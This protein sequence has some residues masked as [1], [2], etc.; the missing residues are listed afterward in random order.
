[1]SVKIEAGA[2]GISPEK[3]ENIYP[4]P[5]SDLKLPNDPDFYIMTAVQQR[6]VLN[7]AYTEAYYLLLAGQHSFIEVI[8]LT[9]LQPFQLYLL[10]SGKE[11]KFPLKIDFYIGPKNR[12]LIEDSVKTSIFHLLKTPRDIAYYSK[13]FDLSPG[14]I[15][16]WCKDSLQAV[17]ASFFETMSKSEKLYAHSIAL[18]L[19]LSGQYSFI[20]ILTI[21]G[22]HPY[23]LVEKI[24]RGKIEI[25]IDAETQTL[26]DASL[27]KLVFSPPKNFNMFIF[28][29]YFGIK[30]ETII[31]WYQEAGIPLP[32][33]LVAAD[34]TLWLYQ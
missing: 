29:Y 6:S 25:Q 34:E 18:E 5:A 21:T 20:E 9:G 24:W 7:E 28:E 13:M 32:L 2:G 12:Q 22:L 1:M 8:D 4:L 19:L 30:E 15:G 10:I 27:R 33:N 11:K 14:I 17:D 26:I 3:I 31:S 16:S 23:H